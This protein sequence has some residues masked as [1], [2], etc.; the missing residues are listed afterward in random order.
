[1]KKYII[2]LFL[3]IQAGGAI[4]LVASQSAQAVAGATA[5]TP[6]V[7]STGATLA[8]V[9]IS[10]FVGSACSV[11]LT[12][13]K[14]NT[15]TPVAN[16][17]SA[18]Q[19]AC[20]WYSCNPVV[21]T[22]HT[23]SGTGNYTNIAALVYSGTTTSACLGSHSEGSNAGSTVQPGSVTPSNNNSLLITVL[24]TDQNV[25]FSID[26]SFNVEQQIPSG[27]VS[28]SIATADQVQTTATTRN[29]TWTLGSG[30]TS[31]NAAAIAVFKPAGAA[32]PSNNQRRG[33]V[34]F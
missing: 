28:L 21:G 6:A 19:N 2:A 7:N 4:V 29:P 32:P 26:S 10:N 24:A 9:T 15:Y 16:S 5:T 31:S 17:V 20:I 13:S 27:G 18:N 14:G 3:C 30:A 34:I 23:F 1:M 12:D 33:T 25:S 11:T 22:G 8:V